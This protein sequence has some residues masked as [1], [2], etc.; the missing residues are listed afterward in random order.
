MRSYSLNGTLGYAGY[1]PDDVVVRDGKISGK[2][3]KRRSDIRTWH[4]APH[5]VLANMHLPASSKVLARFFRQYGA[6]DVSVQYRD[7]MIGWG[8]EGV[9]GPHTPSGPA[10]E[11]LNL[12]HADLVKQDFS[13]T[14]QALAESQ[15]ILR[16]A[17]RGDFTAFLQLEQS[18]KRGEFLV[19]SPVRHEDDLL[20][21]RDLWSFICYIFL[22]DYERDKAKICGFRDCSTPYFVQVRKDQL[23]CSHSCAVKDNNLR[24][25]QASKS[26][27]KS[28]RRTR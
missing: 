4:D 17:W 9:V 10:S 3:G 27:F 6:F 19:A 26:K 12:G 8:E 16:M 28:R 13:L 22:L 7:D 20:T 24:R 14:F 11:A 2:L 1:L 25:A 5:V 21:T 15:T 18:V 23:Y